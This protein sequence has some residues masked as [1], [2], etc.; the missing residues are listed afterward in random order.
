[1]ATKKKGAAK[2]PAA[3]KPAAK[4]APARKAAAK[5]GGNLKFFGGRE[6]AA[7]PRSMSLQPNKCGECGF[8]SNESRLCQNPMCPFFGMAV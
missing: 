4:K 6:S 5:K 8:A 2:K 1:M 7:P 3:K